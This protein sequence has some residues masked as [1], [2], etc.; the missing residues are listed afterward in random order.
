MQ[1]LQELLTLDPGHAGARVQRGL[2]LTAALRHDDALLDFGAVLA[3]EPDNAEA[4]A[5][6]GG[7]F[8][9]LQNLDLAERDLTRALT[10]RPDS[11]SAL[12]DLGN[13][14]QDRQD[15]DRAIGCYDRALAI[16][17]ANVTAHSNRATALQ[18]THRYDEAAAA[19]R[20]A[21]E[22]GPDQHEAKVC[23][24]LCHLH[25]GRWE[26]GW[27]DYEARW[28]VPRWADTI[29]AFAAP[30]WDGTSDL[31]GKRV[32]VISELGLGDTLQFCRFVHCLADRGATA[33]LGVAPPLKRLMATV[34]GVAEVAVAG[35]KPP[36]YDCYVPLLSLIHTFGLGIGALD[37]TV[38]YLRA[39][40]EAVARWRT[41][42]AGL[43]GLK[44]GL[45]W[46]GDPRKDDRTAFRTDMRRSLPL[47]QWGPILAVTGVTFVSLQKGPESA[48]AAGL[49]VAGWMDEIEDFADTAALAEAL[50]LVISVD[51]SVVHLAGG[52]GKPVWVLN[53]FDRCWRWMWDR[54]DTPWYPLMRLFTQS[55]PGVWADPVAEVA[56]ALDQLAKGSVQA[57]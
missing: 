25:A 12:I 53:R 40:P 47:A 26:E 9:Y 30:R 39:E 35:E 10:L 43:P 33:I 2:L 22:I 3:T 32:M 29:P 13:V 42:L 19:Y 44:V 18:M 37:G 15:Y 36:P 20:R 50:D 5:G 14:W 51:T 11:V 57:L 31:T 45:T 49:P 48:Q 17:P 46:A 27:H 54:T 38:P 34:D 8:W 41:R 21:A 23:I 28:N 24:A 16:Q 7:V 4:L 56:A 52:L 55:R 6:R 1:A